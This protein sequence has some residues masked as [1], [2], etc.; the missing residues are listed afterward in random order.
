[1]KFVIFP[2]SLDFIHTEVNLL[3]KSL[4]FHPLVGFIFHVLGV[5]VTGIS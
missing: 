5:S 1:M 2:C 3:K 4:G